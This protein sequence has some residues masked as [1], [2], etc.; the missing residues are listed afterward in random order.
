[1]SLFFTGV[2]LTTAE[3]LVVQGLLVARGMSDGSTW[4]NEFTAWVGD[5]RIGIRTRELST[6]PQLRYIDYFG[7]GTTSYTCA[8]LSDPS[9][10]RTVLQQ[11]PGNELR[12]V[13]ST[14]IKRS[15]DATLIINPT[16]VPDYHAAITPIWLA[17]NGGCYYRDRL[18][19]TQQ[20]VFPV[21]EGYSVGLMIQHSGV[22]VST[23]SSGQSK[24]PFFLSEWSEFQPNKLFRIK[25]RAVVKENWPPSFKGKIISATY[26]VLSWTN[27]GGFQ[28][29]QQFKAE[30]YIPDLDA[31]STARLI[32]IT[33]FTGTVTNAELTSIEAIPSIKV[34]PR[35][36]VIENRLAHDKAAA[37]PGI[38]YDTIDGKL[39]S[40]EEVKNL[41]VYARRLR[42]VRPLSKASRLLTYILLAGAVAIPLFLWAKDSRKRQPTEMDGKHA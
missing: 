5:C 20:P 9:P 16:P 8:V 38:A 39:L 3:T 17:L 25:D 7:D 36:R 31:T 11:G 1:M 10:T 40:L 18:E 35:T 27:A 37:I 2:S 29:P 12:R 23:D 13:E 41:D 21:G 24:R 34:L 28:I 42:N 6:N 32:L 15:S 22:A 30:K 4:T 33:S 26:Q 14:A 19:K